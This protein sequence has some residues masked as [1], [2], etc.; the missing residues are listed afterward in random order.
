MDN[1]DDR[2]TDKGH[3]E[4][5]TNRYKSI[6]KDGQTDNMIFRKTDKQTEIH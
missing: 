5:Q 1:K 4:R 2:Q 6:K 3:S